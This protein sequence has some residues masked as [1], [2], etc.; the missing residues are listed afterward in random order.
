VIAVAEIHGTQLLLDIT[1]GTT[2]SGMDT[3]EYTGT[4]GWIVSETDP[5]WVGIYSPKGRDPVGIE[6]TFRL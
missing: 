3:R 1:S 5:G 4:Q 6:S 2:G